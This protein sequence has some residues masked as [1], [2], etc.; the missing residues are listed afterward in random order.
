MK[1]IAER[2]LKFG[3]S[4][5]GASILDLHSGALSQGNSFINFYKL[6]NTHKVFTDQDFMIY[7]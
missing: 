7:K 3:G 5:G 6:E 4:A 1:N 2:G